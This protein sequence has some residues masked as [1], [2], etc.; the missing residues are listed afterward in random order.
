M[1]FVANLPCYIKPA[2]GSRFFSQTFNFVT[3]RHKHKQL[4]SQVVLYSLIFHTLSETRG[5]YKS[6]FRSNEHY[7]GCSEN[8][9]GKKFRPARGD[10]NFF[11]KRSP[12][13]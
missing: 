11:Q 9:A 10:N 13:L 4:T 1:S 7:L 3:F 8:K 12:K 6:D 2:Y 5:E